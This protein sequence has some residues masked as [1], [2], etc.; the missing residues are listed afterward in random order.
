M[1]LSYISRQDLESSLLEE[2]DVKLK[3]SN[4]NIVNTSDIYPVDL[5]M[6]APEVL[7]FH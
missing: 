4:C 7:K 3:W 5:E 2:K 1:F 6:S